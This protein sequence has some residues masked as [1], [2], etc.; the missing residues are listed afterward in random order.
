[1]D[2]LTLKDYQQLFSQAALE[3]DQSES[4]PRLLETLT[5]GGTLTGPD[6]IG[7]YANGVTVRLTEAL[8][9]TFEAVWWVCGDEDF[10]ALT[11]HF[12]QAQPSTTYNLSKYGKEFPEFLDEVSPFPDLP[13]LGDLARYEWLFKELFHTG[14]HE[15]V[16]P[17]SIQSLT[18]DATIRFRFGHA[19]R[20]FASRYAIY[21]LWKLRGTAHEGEPPAE[22]DHPQFLLLYKKDRQIYINEVGEAEFSVLNA[23]GEG[24]SIETALH[25][26]TEAHP[27]FSQEH[28]SQLFQM[29][30]HTGI[31]QHIEITP[32]L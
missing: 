21:D 11:K 12:I 27:I 18:E 22:W 32:S 13:F 19:V 4:Y 23:L 8:G 14:Q 1:M 17:D 9:E 5:P 28:I 15:S 29:V 25:S 26:A 31:I 6:A 3:G 20:L 7:V 30:F 16:S 10:F 2:R 24:Q